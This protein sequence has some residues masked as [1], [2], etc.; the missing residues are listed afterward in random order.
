MALDD[1][2]EQYRLANIDAGVE[3]HQQGADYQSGF[4]ARGTLSRKPGMVVRDE[5]RP[6]PT[7]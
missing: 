4:G 2:E 1:G 7:P 3:Q 5:T 6:K